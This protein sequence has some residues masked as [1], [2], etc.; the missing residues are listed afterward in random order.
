MSK[1]KLTV[2]QALVYVGQLGF[3]LVVPIV[4]CTAG[5]AWLVHRFTLPS[6]WILAGILL[7]LGASAVPFAHFAKLVQHSAGRAAQHDPAQNSLGGAE[8]AGCFHR[9]ALPDPCGR[10]DPDRA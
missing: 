8:A 6:A 1:K 2:V 9:A 10:A 5:A 4:G 7:G 3:V